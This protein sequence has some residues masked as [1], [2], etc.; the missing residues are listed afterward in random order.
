M[1]LTCPKFFIQVQYM[2][3]I[4]YSIVCTRLDLAHAINLLSKYMSNPSR[5]RALACDGI[6]FEIY[7]W[8]YKSKFEVY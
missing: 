4:M 5:E 7:W 6:V 1:Q 3:S 2:G 8:D